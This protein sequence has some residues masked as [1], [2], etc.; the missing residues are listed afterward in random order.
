[1]KRILFCCSFLS[2]VFDFQS[3]KFSVEVLLNA[4]M[5]TEEHSSFGGISPT[6]GVM[7]EGRRVQPQVHPSLKK[8]KN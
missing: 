2:A 7:K 8:K 3:L 6:A 1:M 4:Y 5:Q